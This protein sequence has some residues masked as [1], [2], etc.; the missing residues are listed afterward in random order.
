[1]TTQIF[2]LDSIPNVVAIAITRTHFVENG[3]FFLDFSQPL[4]KIRKFNAFNIN[5]GPVEGVLV[6]LIHQ[7]GGDG[8]VIGM[9]KNESYYKN[10]LNFWKDNYP[11][12]VLFKENNSDNIKVMTD[13]AVQFPESC[14]V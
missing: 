6:P 7:D 14:Q 10:V 11:S 8:L 2:R 13:F 5:F 12:E 1:M 4:N 3:L 9:H